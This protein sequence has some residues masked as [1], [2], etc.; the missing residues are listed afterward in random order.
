MTAPTRR[1][2]VGVTPMES[3]H[4]VVL[5]LAERAEELGY[6]AFLLAEGWGHDAPVLLGTIA[7]R[8]SRIRLGTGVLNVWGRSPAG[9][10]MLA[11]SL[12]AVSGGRF[13]LGLGAGSPQLAEGWHDQR[14]AVPVA[15]LESVTREVR[16]LLAGERMSPSLA[17]GQRPLRLA[18]EPRP[19]IPVHLAGLGP[20]AVRLAGEIADAWYPFLLPRSGLPDGVQLLQDGAI[21]AAR[22]V[23]LVSPGLPVAVARDPATAR[24]MASWWVVTYLTGMGPI[25]GRTLRRL[26]LGGAVDVVLDA[27][28]TRGSTEI[29]SDAQ[30]LIDELVISGSAETGRAGIAGWFDA[31]AE[32]PVLVLPPGRPVAELEYALEVLRPTDVR[33]R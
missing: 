1:L 11:A 10:A 4:E 21:D 31:G 23:P 16:A 30:V 12:D 6:D 8:T 33:S 2:A 7:A 20:R 9:I 22:P 24:A 15:R 25:Y 5:H 32:L 14:F 28:R 3:R 26:G 13:V 29:P 27:N 19:G 17:D 18:V